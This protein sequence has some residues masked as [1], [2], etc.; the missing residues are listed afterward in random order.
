MSRRQKADDGKQLN[1]GIKNSRWKQI[2]YYGS[3]LK[4]TSNDLT[5]I[6]KRDNDRHFL[7][8]LPKL[9]RTTY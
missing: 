8:S 9:I 5:P 6:G 7:L 1:E 2:C 3:L 4:S